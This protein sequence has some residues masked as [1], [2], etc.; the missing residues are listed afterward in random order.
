MD[1]CINKSARAFSPAE[2]KESE[3][4]QS[5]PTLGDPMDSSLH[6]AP[7]SM[8][9]SR[10]EYWSGLPFPSPG[11]LPNPGLNPGLPHCGQMLYCLNHQEIK[12]YVSRANLLSQRIFFLHLLPTCLCHSWLY[13]FLSLLG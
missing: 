3:V 12:V 11:D 13:V 7:P 8:E 1:T 6:Q 5:Y 9:F 4:A 2:R 10:Q